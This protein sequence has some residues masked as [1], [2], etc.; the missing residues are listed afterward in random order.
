MKLTHRRRELLKN[1]ERPCADWSKDII[2]L[3]RLDLVGDVKEQE[4]ANRL[5][6]DVIRK[7]NLYTKETRHVKIISAVDN[8]WDN[9]DLDKRDWYE[10]KRED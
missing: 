6:R 4:K 8:V 2:W 10:G 3:K 9:T 7:H 1:T 5:F